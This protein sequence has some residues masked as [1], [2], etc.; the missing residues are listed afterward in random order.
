MKLKDH[1]KTHLTRADK[2]MLAALDVDIDTFI[3]LKLKRCN[4]KNRE[5]TRCKMKALP[6]KTKCGLHGGLS[7]GPKTKEGKAK[8]TKNFPHM[9][10]K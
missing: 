3:K 7:T 8:V 4:A 6:G 9:K 2:A 5:G 1:F 10:N